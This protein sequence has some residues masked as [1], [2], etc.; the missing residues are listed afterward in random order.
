MAEGYGGVET[1]QEK[2]LL[3]VDDEANILRSLSRLLRRDGYTIL[4]ANGGREGL[5]I[6]QQQPVQV[7]ISDQRMPEMSGVE[8]LSRARELY[9]ET[10]RIALSGYTDLNSVTE[11]VNKGAIYKFL[12][13]PWEDDELRQHISDAFELYH[14]NAGP[15]M[16]HG[17]MGDTT[18]ASPETPDQNCTVEHKLTLPMLE[19]IINAL[20]QA[21]LVFDHQQHVVC[22][23]PK[24]CQWFCS[25]PANTQGWPSSLHGFPDE[26]LGWI[27][28]VNTQGGSIHRTLSTPQ[29]KHWD[30]EVHPLPA[31]PNAPAVM[32]SLRPTAGTTVDAN[33][34]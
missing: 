26:V 12:T 24:A 15:R 29:D 4:T 14:K 16:A 32:V 31:W 17:T 5:E 1:V 3:L 20:P 25:N 30:V 13:K 28:Q 27:E 10:I 9:P 7:I 21:I 11:A 19:M 33:H 22:G 34:V 2:V 6:L 18:A 8:F 23:N